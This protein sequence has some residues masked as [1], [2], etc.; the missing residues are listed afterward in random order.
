MGHSKKKERSFATPDL[1][2]WEGEARETMWQWLRKTR[3]PL[4]ITTS[5]QASSHPNRLCSN[6]STCHVGCFGWTSKILRAVE[7]LRCV[8]SPCRD[9]YL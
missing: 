3:P 6:N 8:G 5:K 1:P 2:D 4:I 9:S 7:V